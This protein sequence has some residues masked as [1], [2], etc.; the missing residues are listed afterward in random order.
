MFKVAPFLERLV[1]TVYSNAFSTFRSVISLLKNPKRVSPGETAEL[2]WHNDVLLALSLQSRRIHSLS[3]QKGSTLPPSPRKKLFFAGVVISYPQE[4]KRAVLESL[5][6]H[7]CSCLLCPS[8]HGYNNSS[9]QRRG[10]HN[11]QARQTPLMKT[12]PWERKK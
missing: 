4:E 5:Q 8:E 11:L 6:I 1:M 3:E 7:I 9:I 12:N 2:C 10:T